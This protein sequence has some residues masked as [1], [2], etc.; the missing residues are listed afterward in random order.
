MSD[1]LHPPQN[2]SIEALGETTAFTGRFG[3]QKMAVVGAYVLA[4]A[5]TVMWALSS[6][7]NLDNPLGATVEA[8]RVISASDEYWFLLQNES[9]TDWTN[10]RMFLNDKYVYR[11]LPTLTGNQTDKVFV[12]DFQYIYYVPRAQYLGTLEDTAETPA[13][14]RAPKDLKPQKLVI[15]TQEG[16]HTWSA[17]Q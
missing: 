5:L 17:P 3:R 12:K 8:K 14:P 15:R 6:P 2:K 9:S 1:S 13:S 11:G 10:V 16:T 4:S 7:S